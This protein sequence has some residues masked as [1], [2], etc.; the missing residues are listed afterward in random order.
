MQAITL[1]VNMDKVYN[2]IEVVCI[3]ASVTM[4]YL[5]LLSFNVKGTVFGV[6]GA[7]ATFGVAGWAAIQNVELTDGII[8]FLRDAG[9]LCLIVVVVFCLYSLFSGYHISDEEK[10]RIVLLSTCILAASILNLVVLYI[11][12]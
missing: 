2:V 9:R 8:G 11:L 4:L 12:S 5:G 3:L 6:L 7:I 1:S 10:E